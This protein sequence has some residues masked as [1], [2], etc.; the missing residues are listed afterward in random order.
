M[1]LPVQTFARIGFGLSSMAAL[2]WVLWPSSF[3]FLKEPEPIFAF[4]TAFAVW[5][6]AE[7]K[8]S[9]EFNSATQSQ[10][11]PTKNDIRRTR[12]IA[13][14][15]G[16]QFR[17][18]LKDWDIGAGV[19]PRYVSELGLLFREIKADIFFFNDTQAN[20][21]LHE[22]LQRLDDF[23]SCFAVHSSREKYGA[24]MLQHVIPY[25]VKVAGF[26]E[27]KYLDEIDE[28]NRLASLAWDAFDVLYQFLRT[29]FPTAFDEPIEY[30]W[31]VEERD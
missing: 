18:I 6:M 13:G 14:Y 3:S 17:Y 20:Q 21:K 8:I 24:Q 12:E 2:C 19:E 16:D 4:V 7:F 1:R 26:V 27:Q 5:M 10:F 30:I 28:A 23:V 29:E 15:H 9:E 22:F 11:E 31:R 25:R